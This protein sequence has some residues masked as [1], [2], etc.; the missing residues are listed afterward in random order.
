MK[1]SSGPW[2]PVYEML[3]MASSGLCGE[4]ISTVAQVMGEELFREYRVLYVPSS[5]LVDPSVLWVQISLFSD[6]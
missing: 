2:S 1:G 3:S 4:S 5:P 6:F